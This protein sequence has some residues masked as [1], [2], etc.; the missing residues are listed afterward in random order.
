MKF[1]KRRHRDYESIE[2][3][4]DDLELLRRR[5]NP[6]ERNSEKNLTIALKFKRGD[7]L[8]T[9]LVTRYTFSADYVPKPHDLRTKSRNHLL[10]K[11]KLKLKINTLVMVFIVA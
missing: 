11:P 10:M 7:E 2:K 4:L 3:F 1:E 6:E 8:K 9:I 5:S